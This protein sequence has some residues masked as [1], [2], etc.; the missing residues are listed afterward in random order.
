MSVHPYQT[1]SGRKWESRWRDADG[2]QRRKKGFPTKREAQL[3][4]SS[5]EV[6]TA[7][8]E[9][10]DPKLGRVTFGQLGQ[11]WLPQ[12]T[13][14]KPSTR[15]HTEVWY[16]KYVEPKFG[17]RAVGSV[18]PSE[19][20]AWVA[21]L[22]AEGRGV[23]TIER[24]VGI[25]RG[26]FEMAVE[27]GL[28]AS[29]PVQ[30]VRL[31]R[32]APRHREIL[33]LDQFNLVL[34]ELSP[35]HYRTF[36][37]CLAWTGC[38]FGE[39]T[40]LQ[41]RSCDLLRRRLRIERSLSEVGGRFVVTTPK[42]ATSVRVVSLPA[43]LVEPLSRLMVGK[44]P[45]DP[46]FTTPRGRLIRNTLFRP[47]VFYPAVE[48]A[49]LVDPTIP[50]TRVH[51]LRHFAATQAIAAGAS[52]KAV[53]ALLGHASARQTLDRYSHVLP[54]DTDRIAEAFDRLRTAPE[55]TRRTHAQDGAG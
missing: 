34:D 1:G 49:R 20:R 13:H 46:V 38:R 6:A 17:D 22:H 37:E 50:P 45:E 11:R 27:D 29:S 24:V 15:Y 4:D 31:P 19:I 52:V 42:T 5:R 55:D 25:V 9:W 10:V 28:V 54:D 2:K 16:R 35:Q 47:D 8:G 43:S 44:G 39:L 7:R 3:F 36:V 53:Q 21:E 26:V 14:L 12:Q 40:G 51:D 33:T 30:R 41:V 32:E 18:K 48:A 23:G